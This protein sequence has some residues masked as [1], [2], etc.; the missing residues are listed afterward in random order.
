MR[1]NME[2]VDELHNKIKNYLEDIN[3]RRSDLE[4][5]KGELDEIIAETRSD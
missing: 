3:E 1:E 4:I 5:K 2:I